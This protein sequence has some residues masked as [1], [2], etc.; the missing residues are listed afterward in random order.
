[1]LKVKV[2][3]SKIIPDEALCGY[4]LYGEFQPEKQ[5]R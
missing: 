1:V 2:E 3:V 5:I 4:F